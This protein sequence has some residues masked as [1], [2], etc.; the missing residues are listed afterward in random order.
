MSNIRLKHK[1]DLLTIRLCFL[2]FFS[3]HESPS[4]THF[5]FIYEIDNH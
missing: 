5:V 2:Y 1:Y 3:I 4:F